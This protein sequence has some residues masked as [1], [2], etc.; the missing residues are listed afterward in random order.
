M[1]PYIDPGE[2][3]MFARAQKVQ[4]RAGLLEDKQLQVLQ[5]QQ[6]EQ[7]ARDFANKLF[8]DN[9]SVDAQTGSVSI[10]PQYFKDALKLATLPDAPPDLAR[11]TIDWGEHSR[12]LRPP[13]CKTIRKHG[14]IYRLPVV[15]STKSDHARRSERHKLTAS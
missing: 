12:T 8:T 14:R 1:R 10:A 3:T 15:R 7:A 6:N 4:E 5:K 2:L 13:R 11:T 9:V